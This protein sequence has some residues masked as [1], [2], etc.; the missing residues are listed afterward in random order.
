MDREVSL[1]GSGRPY[2]L[3]AWSGKITPIAGYKS[4][5]GRVTVK[6]RLSRDNAMLIAL[7]EDPRRFGVTKP[8]IPSVIGTAVATIDL[9]KATWHIV[10]E[11]WQPTNPYITTFGPA[12]SETLKTKVEIDV[13]A[14]RAWPE[15]PELQ[16]VSGLATYTTSFD[17]PSKTEGAIL[18]LGEVF[19]TFTL[20]INDQ[21][22][23]IDQ[24]SAE[25]D[26][27]PYLKPGRNTIEVRVA[28]TLNNRLTKIDDDVAKRGIVQP[29]GLVGPVTIRSFPARR[30]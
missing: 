1:E 22:V 18:N 25:A 7:A 20:K 14:L 6:V 11:D 28:T 9:T 26:I 3:D 30:R 19:D 23:S 27:G 4:G 8:A 15:I 5:N 17:W 2:L 16:N 29:Y 24:L 21:A 12:A 10:A 13:T